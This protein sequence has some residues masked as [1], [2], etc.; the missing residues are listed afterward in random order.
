MVSQQSTS[1]QSSSHVR[2][3]RWLRVDPPVWGFFPRGF[4]PLLGLLLLSAYG[5]T[6]FAKRDVEARVINRTEVLLREQGLSHLKVA[7]SGQQVHLS[8]VERTAGDGARAID[9]ATKATCDTWTGDRTCAISVDGSFDKPKATNPWPDHE[10][11]LEGGVLTLRGEVADNAMKTAIVADAQKL[12]GANIT[13]VV[14]QLRVAPQ[15]VQDGQAALL[16]R[17]LQHVARCQ[18]GQASMTK[19]V[20]SLRC[21]VAADVEAPLRAS[22][23]APLAAPASLGTVQLLVAAVADACD[24]EF[25]DVLTKSTLEFD[26]GKA[27]LR[28]SSK[29]V[30]D[31]VAAIAQRCPGDLKI[32]GHTD[33][34]GAA[35]MNKALSLA[36]ANA[37]RDG[38]VQ[39]GVP[40]TRLEGRG[41]GPDRPK[42]SNNNDAGRA[43]NRRIEISIAR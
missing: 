38:L 20:W 6:R 5:C 17:S 36:R 37:V 25:A 32:D 11:R 43:Q 22:A 41:F 7:A 23:Q 4:L 14:D 28:G 35:E 2:I 19:L 31:S 33:D 3:R 9:I 10:F 15:A 30:L 1:S 40:A 12:I 8:G 29:R 16:Q 39:R 13:S 26:T 34:R 42:A 18:K 27:T 21:E 24:K